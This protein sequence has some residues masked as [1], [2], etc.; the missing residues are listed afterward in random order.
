MFFKETFGNEVFF[1][2]IMGIFEGPVTLKGITQAI[3]ALNGK[4]TSNLQVKAEENFQAGE[5]KINK[6][7]LINTGIDV[8]KDTYIPIGVKVV[9]D[10]GRLKAG[11]SCALCHATVNQSG[12]VIAGAPNTDLNMG[13][14]LAMGSNTAA[15]FTHTEMES[16]KE[17]IKKDGKV[18]PGTQKEKL[19]DP[20][21]LEQ[22]VDQEIVKYPT[23]SVDTTIDFA[24]NPVQT[25]DSYTF[26][27]HPFGWSGQG[28]IG[29]FKGLSAAINNAHS[30]NMDALS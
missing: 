18:I 23:G 21:L 16:I 10:E 7:D 3:L 12:K 24:N 17:F 11:I 27:D 28:Q 22:F 5:T 2:D 29:P 19:P 13:L 30:Q 26:G 15:Y 25:P 8:A 4:G 6:G 9:F 14:M 1:T 20:D